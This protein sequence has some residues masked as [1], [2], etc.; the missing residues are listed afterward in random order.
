MGTE[1]RAW[2]SAGPTP[3]F[4]WLRAS[5]RAAAKRIYP[6]SANITH[7]AAPSGVNQGRSCEVLPRHGLKTRHC[8]RSVTP[9]AGALCCE[10]SVLHFVP[11]LR[12]RGRLPAFWCNTFAVA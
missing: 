1:I 11:F 5:G 9:W 3:A 4:V 2:S 10:P 6:L 7:I 12:S 8:E